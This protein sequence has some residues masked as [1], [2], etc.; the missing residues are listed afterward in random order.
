MSWMR[1]N[2]V[3]KDDC[4]SGWFVSEGLQCPRHQAVS[5]CTVIITQM[6]QVHVHEWHSLRLASRPPLALEAPLTHDQLP[7]LVSRHGART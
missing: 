7:R 3:L 5:T 2:I 1:L 4:S 6:F